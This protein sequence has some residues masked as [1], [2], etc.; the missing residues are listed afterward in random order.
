MEF[1]GYVAPNYVFDAYSGGLKFAGLY[2]VLV[3]YLMSFGI[4]GGVELLRVRIEWRHTS[5]SCAISRRCCFDFAESFCCT[6]RRRDM[7]SLSCTLSLFWA[8]G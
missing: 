8:G 7:E 5:R 4:G 2:G 6:M 1:R 3:H